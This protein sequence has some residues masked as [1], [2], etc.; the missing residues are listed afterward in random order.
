MTANK[1]KSAG[2]LDGVRVVELGSGVGAGFCGRLLSLL[3]AEVTALRTQ[4]HSTVPDQL[5]AAVPANPAEQLYLGNG[6]R[7]T[8]VTGDREEWLSQVAGADVVV[9]GLE[10]ASGGTPPDLHAVYERL[11]A[12]RPGLIFAA[13][14]PFGLDGPLA[15][16]AGGDLNAQALSGWTSIVGNPGEAPLSMGY[17]VAGMQQGLSAAG[18]IVVALLVNDQ[19][20]EFIDIS[21]AE[22]IAALIH[23]YEGTYRF[24]GIPLVRS[25]HRA[26]GSSGRYPH[27]MLPCKDGEVILICR[28]IPEWDRL[29]AMMGN[30]PWGTESRYRDFHAMATEYPGEVDALISP[31]LM[32]HTKA[33]LVLLARRFRVPLAP[34]RTADEVL[35]DPQ[36]AHREFFAEVQ[37]DGGRRVRLPGLP[38]L[39]TRPPE[40]LAGA[41]QAGF[42]S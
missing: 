27:T 32:R 25:G 30:P 21:E 16:S 2:P 6:K 4:P 29:L 24:A 28:S 20:G 35:A 22:V 3:G 26:P 14:T 13:L 37:A 9:Y 19:R 11:R 12:H 5:S 31:W 15:R 38:A 41:A 18:A 33:E 17:G 36:L 10:R 40:P 1:D 8:A 39:W 23:M 7:V 42:A 34:I